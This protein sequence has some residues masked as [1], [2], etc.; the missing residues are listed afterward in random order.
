MKMLAWLILGLAVLLSVV[1]ALPWVRS[2]WWVVRV[3]DFPRVQFGMV[4]LLGV[5]AVGFLMVVGYRSVPM[6]VAL[7]LFGACTIVQAVY[8]VP[9]LPIWPDT[10]P[11]AT[12][13]AGDERV[14]VLISN[15]DY[16]N[17]QREEVARW[18]GGYDLDLL[19]LVEVDDEWMA[20]L[21]DVRERYEHRLEAV[22]P[23]GLGIVLWSKM[24]LSDATVEHLV[25]DDR[26]SLRAMIHLPNGWRFAI[27]AVHPTPPGLEGDDGD[28]QDS[29]KRDA[30][31]ILL[32]KRIADE[33]RTARLVVGDLNDAAWS[34]TTRL[35]LR[36]S[37]MMDPRRGRGLFSTYPASRPLLRFPIDHVFVSDG[38]R[39]RDLRRETAPGSDHLAMFADLELTETEGVSPDPEKSD[40]E[41][42]EEIIDEGQEDAS[43]DARD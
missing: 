32:A 12:Q 42:G 7:G 20:A 22:R 41:D 16:E 13:S 24:E 34:H 1:T 40:R 33:P 17:E 35:F 10:V 27:N 43:E 39:V 9:F 2:G 28:R 29:R 19:V 26:P 14:R 4:C 31:L 5:V 8:V 18:L 38:F 11:G 25:S 30:E 6:A 3:C 23:E 37:G 15:L 36:L 21:G